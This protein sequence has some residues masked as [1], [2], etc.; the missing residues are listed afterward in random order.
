M[1]THHCPTHP[2]GDTWQPDGIN[3][4]P[5]HG[6]SGH[7]Q[8][9]KLGWQNTTKTTRVDGPPEAN[10]FQREHRSGRVDAKVMATPASLR[11]GVENVN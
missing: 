2:S 11:A 5:H 10:N 8:P 3:Q 6:Q 7:A 1:K 4:C 9:F